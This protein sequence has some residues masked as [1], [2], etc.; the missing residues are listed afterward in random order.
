[1]DIIS[2]FSAFIISD[3]YLLPEVLCAKTISVHLDNQTLM[4]TFQKYL[5]ELFLTYHSCLM[6]IGVTIY[7]NSTISFF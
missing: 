4:D 7:H 3:N 5:V 6:A 1:M 2:L